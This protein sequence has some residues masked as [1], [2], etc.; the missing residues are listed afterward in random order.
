MGRGR[1]ITEEM[2]DYAQINTDNL[3]NKNIRYYWKKALKN[4]YNSFK[5]F[6]YVSDC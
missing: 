4:K 3:I 2:T 1:E 5:A 6:L